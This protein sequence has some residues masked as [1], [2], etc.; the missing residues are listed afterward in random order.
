MK[1]NYELLKGTTKLFVYLG[2][3]TDYIVKS[4]YK[5]FPGENNYIFGYREVTK[6]NAS[7]TI[8]S[9][10]VYNRCLYCRNGKSNIILV[11][12]VSWAPGDTLQSQMASPTSSFTGNFYGAR[13]V[14]FSPRSNVPEGVGFGEISLIYK[15]K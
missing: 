7:S 11:D 3:L 9:F 4:Y 15:S 10:R 13:L 5:T 12:A 6:G 1:S 14:V 8:L 2:T